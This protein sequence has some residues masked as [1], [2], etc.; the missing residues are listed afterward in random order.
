MGE[1]IPRMVWNSVSLPCVE[2]VD[3]IEFNKI[4]SKKYDGKNGF[5]IRCT[6]NST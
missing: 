6:G 2:V 5:E 4:Y 1:L 3:F